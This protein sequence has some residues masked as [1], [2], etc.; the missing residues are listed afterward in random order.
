MPAIPFTARRR[1]GVLFCLAGFLLTQVS[2]AQPLARR[3][4]FADTPLARNLHGAEALQSLGNRLKDVAEF[5]RMPEAE[6]RG[7]LQRDR[8]LWLDRQGRLFYVCEFELPPQRG[9]VG[10]STNAPPVNPLYQLTQTFKL[11]SRP[12][13][14]RVIFLD[15]DGHDA[16]TTVWGSGNG[17]AP[18]SRAYDT[19][20]NPS[21]FS[22]AERQSIQFIWGRVAEDYLQY[23]IDVT[24]E[25]PGVAALKNLGTGRYGVRVVIGGDWSD[26]FG[27]SAGG[28]AYLFSFDDA[29]DLPCLVFPKS[30]SDNEKNIA[31]AC[32]HEAGHTLGL[33]HD[34]Q[35][36]GVEYY[37]GHGNWAPIMGVGYDHPIVQW[38]K[39]EYAS[40][41]NTEDDLTKMLSFGA[42][43]R[44]DD[45]GN[46]F[47]TA[48][49]LTGVRP[50][51][52]GI[53]GSSTDVDYFSFQA[54]AGR[55]TI[56]C[57][58]GPRGPNL[59]ILLSLYDSTGALITSANVADNATTGVLP[60]TISPTLPT[61]TYFVSVDG[62]GYL[63]PLNTGYSDYASLGQYT[64]LVTLPGDG[65]WS[66]TSG[67]SYSWTNE[68]NWVSATIPLGASATMRINNNIAGDQ[69]VGTDMP[70]TI[71]GLTVGDADDSH[72]FTLSA[73]GPGLLRF[74]VT[75][76]SAWINKATG[77]DD[78]ITAPLQLLNN[79]AVTNT[80]AYD[81]VLAGPVSGPF[82]LTKSGPGRLVLA[83]TNSGGAGLVVAGGPLLLSDTASVA[84]VTAVTVQTGAVLDVSPQPVGWSLGFSQTLSGSGVVTGNVAMVSGSRL[85]PGA[86]GSPGT[87]TFANQL[88]L[89]AGSAL[90]LN[91]S[92]TT[93]AG[94]GIND[95][96]AVAGNLVLNGVVTV[97][98]DFAG[99]LPETNGGYTILTYA[100]SL[101]GGASNFVAA[102]AG[103]RFAYTFDDS[104]P[105]E[106]R[107]HVSGAPA[108]LVW[109]GGALGNLWDIGGTT[110]WLN[111]GN[112][113]AFFQGDA[114]MFDPSGSTAPALNLSG[115]V[116][117]ASVT[118]SNTTGYTFTG[119]GRIGGNTTIT[120]QGA[121][122]L[123]LVTS[124]DFGGLTFVQDGKLILGNAAALG[125]TNVGTTVS[126]TGQLD[127]NGFAVDNERLTLSGNGPAGDGAVINTGASQTNAIRLVTLTGDTTL[128]GSARWDI[129]GVPASNIVASLTG[130][131]FSLTKTGANQ[132]WFANLGSMS[133]GN[134]TVNQGTLGFEGANT[135][136]NA[137]APLT[138]NA[139]AT[140]AFRNAYDSDFGKVLVLNSCTLQNDSGHNNLTGSSATLSGVVNTSVGEGAVLD[141]RGFVGGAG[142]FDKTGEGI[143]RLAGANSFS[144]NV[145]IS[146]GTVMAGN[147]AALGSVAGSTTIAAGARLDVA[148]FNLG[149]EQIFV[150][151]SGINGRGAIVNSLPNSQQNALRFVTLN[152]DTTL[153]GNGRWDLRANPTG[154][155]LGAFNLTKV[156]QNEIW[157]VNLDATQLKTI[158]VN[159]GTLGFQGTTTMGDPTSTMTVN[160][161][162]TLGVSGTGASVLN[163]T[164]SLSSGRISNGGGSNTFAGSVSLASSNQIDIASG[165]TLVLGGTVNGTGYFGKTS[166]GTLILGGSYTASGASYVNAG[167]LQIGAGGSSGSFGAT[168]NNSASLFFNRTTDLTHAAVINGN[169]TL[170][171][172]NTNTL[173]LS[174]ANTYSGAIT[175]SGGKLRVGSVSA[176]GSTAGGTIVANGATLDVNGFNLGAEVITASGPGVGGGGAVI[177]TGASQNNALQFLT[178]AG[179]TTLGGSARWDLRSAGG[180][181]A[182]SAGGQ[183]YSLTKTGANTIALNSVTV[184][185]ALG[186]IAV[187]QGVLSLEEGTTGLG[188]PS[189]TLTIS[190]GAALN[191]YSLTNGLNKAIVVENGGKLSHSG[192]VSGGTNSTMTGSITLSAGD[193]FFENSSTAYSLQVDS[194]VDGI[195]NFNKTG[196][197]LVQL[198][199][200][201][202][203]GGASVISTGTLKLG[204]FATLGVTPA[205]AIAGGAVF[206]VSALGG[207]FVLNP[208]QT[209]S[210]N[211]SVTGDVIA[212]GVIAPGA[213]I[214]KLT[215]TGNLTLAGNTIMEL[216]KAGTALTNDLLN[217]S[218]TL[219]CGGTLTATH[220]G[221]A[222]VVSNSFHLFSAGTMTGAFGS[223]ALPT[224]SPGLTWN[225]STLPTDGWLR[226]VSNTPPVIGR[227]A[228]NGNELIISGSGGAPGATYLVMMATNVALPLIQWLP[229]ATNAFD[230]GGNF[231][232]TNAIAPATGQ[233]FFRLHVP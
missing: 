211:G 143:L 138:V 11:H 122:T 40:A 128:G 134:I 225:A 42:I 201:N 5:H 214:G 113:D 159:R 82:T 14:S 141:L 182:L 176:L 101:S 108:P 60:V 107:V 219:T 75:N 70:I 54:G 33:S 66:P 73:S 72:H 208:A 222:L 172:Q 4:P 106:I 85:S 142:G 127:L 91:L 102:N 153:G 35:T 206:D 188:N 58:P 47:G 125:L 226:V 74:A 3:P 97:N 180:A 55:T 21:T 190:G 175:V 213:S 23:D 56:T 167:A 174:G 228:I 57:S 25:D 114:V 10:E 220:T 84:S 210:G 161:G 212:N 59:H 189:A 221:N 194:T 184:D 173:T 233:E 170:N 87:L 124:N 110:N 120:K 71:G 145:T 197:G 34:G 88:T 116:A 199:G 20:G 136:A 8:S 80:T 148:A 216:T 104:V 46:N 41:N 22:N 50:F 155:L 94:G 98:F 105:G 146:A 45:Y 154:A 92:S 156:G 61:G 131:G 181:A 229:V 137:S 203:H 69:V 187:Q 51:R 28:V 157:L 126:G 224:L 164:L 202:N 123:T 77:L 2:P 93:N 65:A 177:N 227:V 9:P 64:L 13:A 166:T 36:T 12:G 6:L 17:N 90:D 32:S 49:P 160:S 139:G 52:W 112:S 81:L 135:M 192:P 16:S 117:P 48:S 99:A 83:G 223:L 179:D 38:S 67:G 119:S 27:Q 96:I 121:G 7:L 78:S 196:V 186:N 193:A 130:N 144:G 53:I 133:L 1:L 231:G 129:R 152:G 39:G 140:L 200:A 132:I 18:I 115:I 62:I 218:G 95:L 118:V 68:A 149:A 205:I 43:N 76:G 86:P 162:G 209:L 171:K 163:K 169:G 63:N 198:N 204:T 44:P 185:A 24:T 232:F 31:E 151:G 158:T 217:V 147:T 191:L 168:L 103:N 183:P 178:L 207:G 15:F 19:D 230:A 37:A 30:L 79:L 111:A 109:Q 29:E 100:G 26:W 165:T 195:G 215:I 150:T 89:T